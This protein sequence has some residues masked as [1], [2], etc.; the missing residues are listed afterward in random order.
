MIENVIETTELCRHCL[1]CR[2][3]TPM[4]HITSKE[5]YTPHGFAQLV[6]SEKRDMIEWNEEYAEVM[7]VSSDNGN[8]RAHCV[9]DQPLPEAIAEVRAKL[10]K[11]DLAPDVVYELKEQLKTYET[12][13]AE[14]EP[15]DVSGSGD[16]A[17]FVSDDVRYRSPDTLE[18]VLA[19]LE[20][21]GVN[22][23]R[24]G[25]G[26]NNGFIASSLGLPNVAESLAE[27]TL[28]ELRDVGADRLLVMSPGDY[29]A[30][31]QLYDER[32]GI[33]LSDDVELLEVTDLL[34]EAMDDGS[35]STDERELGEPYAYVDPNHTVRVKSRTD[36]PRTI[37]DELL[38]D[39]RREL[40][41]R[42]ERAFPCGN[43]ALEFVHPD[44]ADELTEFRFEDASDQEVDV[45]VTDGA[46]TEYQLKQHAD[47]FDMDVRNL[48][49]L[50]AEQAT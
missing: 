31:N 14:S 26:R 25:N 22:P 34:A 33:E 5:T 45:L 43:L 17:L 32:L 35:L 13:Y 8:S 36:Q 44:L 24:I 49:G 42:E 4:G 38:A 19:L 29:F 7:Y 18:A 21:V 28:D 2:H 23:V 1:M 46:G 3:K 41:W 39:E 50:L 15:G 40:F 20:E 9:T 47:E 10:V 11:N 30:F 27:A 37:L 12:P 48:Y 6:A 16:V